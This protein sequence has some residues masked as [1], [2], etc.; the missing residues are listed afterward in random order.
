VEKIS[1]GCILDVLDEYGNWQLSIVID[2]SNPKERKMHFLP[3]HNSN[4]DETFK[5]E[6]S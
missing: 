5:D 2:D 1:A 6:D 3:Y 4:R